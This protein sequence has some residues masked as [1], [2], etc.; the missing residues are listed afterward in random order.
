MNDYTAAEKLKGVERE[1]YMRRKV[2]PAMIAKN[3]ITQ[4]MAAKHRSP[5]WRR[6]RRTTGRMPTK[7]KE[8]KMS[9]L[10]HVELFVA[11]DYLADILGM[12]A[13]IGKVRMIRD[14]ENARD[15]RLAE[16]P[17]QAPA[18][19]NPEAQAGT[20]QDWRTGQ[21]SGNGAQA[22]ERTR[23]R[24]IERDQENRQDPTSS[25]SSPIWSRRTSSSAPTR[26][27]Q[28]AVT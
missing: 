7:R 21:D 23:W 1:L 26:T 20:P 18:K 24:V 27:L 10:F 28:G 12:A 4:K 14:G 3:Q 2:Y 13:D 11:E 19:A 15:R 17:T 8:A 5:S 6:S 22:A 16:A 9:R 25:P